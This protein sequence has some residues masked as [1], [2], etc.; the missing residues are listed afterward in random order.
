MVQN[1]LLYSA[2]YITI[3]L[4]FLLQM[5]PCPSDANFSTF[6]DSFRVGSSLALHRQMNGLI[7]EHSNNASVIF[8]ALPNIP[9]SEGQAKEFYDAMDTLS[10]EY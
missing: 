1:L 10:S 3:I 4:L 2:K 7:Q 8:T 9:T 6:S 5:L